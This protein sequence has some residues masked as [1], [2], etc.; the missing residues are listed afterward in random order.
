MKEKDVCDVVKLFIEKMH[1]WEI[2]CNTI[3]LDNSLT[4]QEQFS[5]QK[6][7]LLE[8][9]DFLCTKKERKNGKPNTISYGSNGS[10]EY[11]PSKEVITDAIMDEKSNTKYYVITYREDPLD[12]KFHYVLME[13]NGKWL[14]DAKKIYDES[15][16]AWKSVSL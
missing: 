8:I 5:L 1:Q 11:D 14:I 12:E 13:S 3:A 6:G 16:D 9:F 4:F 7:N 15:K 2:E 10:Y